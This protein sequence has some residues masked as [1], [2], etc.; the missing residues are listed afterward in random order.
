MR[1]IAKTILLSAGILLSLTGCQKGT[2]VGSGKDVKFKASA[3]NLETRT[4]FGD[5]ITENN[6]AIQRCR[7]R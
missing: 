6:L 4:A 5:V 2:T 7:S 1:S 3:N